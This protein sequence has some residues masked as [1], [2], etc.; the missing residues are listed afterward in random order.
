MAVEDTGLKYSL[1]DEALI[2]HRRVGDGAE[3]RTTLPGLFVALAADTVRDFP[4]L[5]PH[6]RHPWHAFLVQLAAIALHAAGRMEPWE[7]EAEWRAA[8]L[9]L[10]PQDPD[11]AA[12][13][14]VAPVTRPAFLQPP[15]PGGTDSTWKPIT[16]ADELDMLV[17]SKNHDLKANRACLAAA[18]DWLFALVSLQ[19][20]DGRPGAGNP[21]ISRMNGAYG[22]RPG[23]GVVTSERPGAHWLRDLSTLLAYRSDVAKTRGLQEDG[24]LA[25]VWLV[26][27]DG[28]T[29]LAFCSLAPYYIEICRR[30]R[31]Q[32]KSNAINALR[33]TSDVERIDAKALKGVTGD[34]WTP[35][36]LSGKA[37]T[38]SSEGFNYKLLVKLL[39][40][41]QYEAPIAQRL[42]AAEGERLTLL[43]QGVTR[44]QGKT[45]GYHERRVPIS[46][47]V[48]SLL[49]SARKD[50]LA[51][52]A[53]ARIAAIEGTRRLLWSALAALFDNGATGDGKAS[54]A[55][56]DKAAVFS[57]P[58]EKAED[59]RFFDDLGAEVEA[60]DAAAQRLQW[61][62][63]LV[64][65]AEAVLAAAFD[66][67]P[68]SGMQ[69]YR[70]QS[71]ALARFHASVR[72][73][74]SPVPELADHY[75][76]QAAQRQEEKALGAR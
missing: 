67:G 74:K 43:A 42:D 52:V 68:R 70:A 35:I 61:E 76:A 45:E 62:R 54:D 66:A 47:K 21:G 75:R 18:D 6:Q 4:A 38:I 20:Q 29:S 58:F 33:T 46:P 65:R 2:T 23:V 64:R 26:T 53:A 5:R 14:L 11:G 56:A 24:G 60:D 22:S 34:P 28:T 36:D 25:L 63:E 37:L 27:W 9:E 39:F 40:G 19:T 49:R 59:A 13:C 73:D 51:Q 12:W 8:L 1:L 30:I 57:R 71:A 55:V 31:L 7:T 3:Q 15:S 44:G 72:G 48:R 50:V 16:T 69:R 41:G 17:T 10:T 32:E